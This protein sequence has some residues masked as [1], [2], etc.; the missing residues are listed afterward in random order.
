MKLPNWYVTLSF[1]SV[2]V[3]MALQLRSFS[4]AIRLGRL[5][6]RKH[7][8]VWL[9]LPEPDEWYL[10]GLPVR[11]FLYSKLGRDFHD[12]EVRSLV[13]R[14][15]HHDRLT[16]VVAVCGMGLSATMLWLAG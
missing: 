1:G 9:D 15:R 6:S 10:P 4:A 8:D 16:L 14:I 2:L 11:R 3:A 7:A 5:L 12:P 13:L